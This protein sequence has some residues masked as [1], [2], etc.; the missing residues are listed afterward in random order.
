MFRFV[1]TLGI[2]VAYVYNYACAPPIGSCL[3]PFLTAHATC[4]MRVTMYCTCCP[5]VL[6]VYMPMA[7]Q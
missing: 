5:V 6:V 7:E 4:A 1:Q 2:L 3:A